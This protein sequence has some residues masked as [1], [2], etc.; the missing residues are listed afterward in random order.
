MNSLPPPPPPPPPP[1]KP[2]LPPPAAAYAGAELSASTAVRVI[3]ARAFIAHRLQHADAAGGHRLR[4]YPRRPRFSQHRS[5]LD[6]HRRIAG[7]HR[8]RPCAPCR[9]GPPPRAQA[10]ASRAWLLRAGGSVARAAVG[11]DA[12]LVVVDRLGARGPALLARHHL[13]FVLEAAARAVHDGV[14]GLRR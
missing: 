7:G 3:S 5:S 4:R 2:E 8:C 6:R 10:R 9:R 11:A 1:W 12:G 13:R 14:L